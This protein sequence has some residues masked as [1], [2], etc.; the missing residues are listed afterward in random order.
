MSEAA[1]YQH[2]LAEDIGEPGQPEGAGARRGWR[3]QV[4][5]HAQVAGLFYQLVANLFFFVYFAVK[6]TLSHF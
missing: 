3:R 6:M 1:Y 2:H 4:L 5:P